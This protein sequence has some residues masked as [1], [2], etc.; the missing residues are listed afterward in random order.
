M[1]YHQPMRKARNISQPDSSIILLRSNGEIVDRNSPRNSFGIMGTIWNQPVRDCLWKIEA[2]TFNE[3]TGEFLL[4]DERGQ[5]FN[6]SSV[7]NLYRLIRPASTHVSAITFAPY[8]KLEVIIAYENGA[9][10][11]LDT[12]SQQVISSISPLPNTSAVSSS[13][14]YCPPAVRIM[15]C[16]PS[17][18]LLAMVANDLTVSLWNLK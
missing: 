17:K 3:K 2:V 13:N 18:P 10:I 12:E 11:L 7:E 6:F 15:H 16:H 1:D 14:G 4:A 5:I 8:R 9:V